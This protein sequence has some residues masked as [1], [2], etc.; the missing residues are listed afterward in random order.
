MTESP[1][2]T[3]VELARYAAHPDVEST[4][5]WVTLWP[6]ERTMYDYRTRARDL[7][8]RMIEAKIDGTKAIFVGDPF[9]PTRGLLNE[10]GTPNDLFLPWCITSKMIGGA[11]YLG[12]LQ[13][14]IV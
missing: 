12:S 2:F 13:L 14:P 10:D 11:E 7:V 6:L 4:C 1:S 3:H 9:D 5:A 8:L